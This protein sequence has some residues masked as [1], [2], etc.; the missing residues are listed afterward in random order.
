MIFFYFLSKDFRNI[1]INSFINL[2][3]RLK[4]NESTEKLGIALAIIAIDHK[5]DTACSFSSI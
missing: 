5:F 4:V 3:F 2:T 1:S